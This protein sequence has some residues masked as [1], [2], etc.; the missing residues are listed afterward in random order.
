[1]GAHCHHAR[2][3]G[4]LTLTVIFEA[5]NPI[6]H[7]KSHIIA[8]VPESPP[9]VTRNLVTK[10][11]F[12]IVPVVVLLPWKRRVWLPERGRKCDMAEAHINRR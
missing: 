8:K 10:C 2:L 1:M 4:V 11:V 5:V 3:A 7:E 9:C 6:C 12:S